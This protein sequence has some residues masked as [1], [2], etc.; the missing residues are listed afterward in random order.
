MPASESSEVK[1]TLFRSV[2]PNAGVVRLL[3]LTRLS[4][5]LVLLLVLGTSRSRASDPTATYEIPP[6]KVPLNVKDQQVTI[7]AS[8]VLAVTKNEQGL[9]IAKLQLSADLSDLQQNLTEVLSSAL[10]KTDGCGDHIAIHNATITP[11]DPASQTVVGLHYERWACAK[12]LGKKE[13]RRLTSGNAVIEMKL[14]PAVD[15]NSTELRLVPDVGRIEADGS[16]GELLRSGPIGEML[17]EKI[18]SAILAAL[19]KGTNLSATLPPALQGYARI[20]N[21]QF[22]DAGSG[23]LAVQMEG[24][25]RVTDEQMQFLTEQVKE[26]MASR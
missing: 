13:A 25:F 10:D 20:Q 23:R 1:M 7:A 9:N 18:R 12:V 19:Q 21:A 26:H 22:Q 16:L 15:E 5:A 4:A 11:L 8:A 2:S 17:R 14:T 3:S 24:E 6:V